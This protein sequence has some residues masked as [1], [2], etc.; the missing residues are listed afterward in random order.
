MKISVEFNTVEEMQEFAKSVHGGCSCSGLT[1]NISNAEAVKDEAP[2]ETAKKKNTS[3]KAEI[4]KEEP[5]KEDAPK[6]EAE[7]TGV[8]ESANNEPVKDA[9]PKEEKT[10]EDEPKVTK[11]QLREIC[12]SVMKAGKQSEVKEV[13]KKYGASKLPELKEEDYAAVYKDVEAL[14]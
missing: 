8:D 5:K 2:K 10:G 13:F 12:A 6:V 14:Q 3:K 9:E 4:K 1:A 11:E 7:V